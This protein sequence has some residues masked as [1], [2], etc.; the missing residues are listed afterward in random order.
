MKGR[1]G[2]EVNRGELA[3]DRREFLKASLVLG[4]ALAVPGGLLAAC[5]GGG[6]RGG[7]GG[8]TRI[9]YQLDWIKNSQF[10]GFYVADSEGY[11]AEEGLQVDL[12]PGADV[13]SHEA[14]V[15]GGG[16][17]IGTSSFLSRTVDAINAG[18]DL[19]VVGA[20]LQRSPIGLLSLPD[21]PI[22]TARDILGKRIGLQEGATAEIRLILEL[23]G[24]PPDDWIEVPVGFDPSPLVEGQVDAYYAYLTNQPLILED[25]GVEY[26]AVSFDELGWEQYGMLAITKRS[27][28][29]ENRDRVV[30]FMRATIKGWERTVADPDLGVRLTMQ[31]GKDLGL[32]ED[33]EAKTLRAQLPFMQSELT[34]QKGLYW[35]DLDRLA[36][37]MYEALRKGGRDRIP[38]PEVLTDLSVLEEVFGGKNRLLES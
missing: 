8:L 29:Q 22:R 26:V 3:L 20:G 19:V 15:A 11:Y 30:G 33:V 6:E 14:V 7:G 24:L 9:R 13:A 2:P 23:N 10:S 32:E 12:L 4:G 35:M 28:L 5:G 1:R 21:N 16:A 31:Y 36:G 18:S 25:M 34:D 38:E 17:E 37:P 27:Y